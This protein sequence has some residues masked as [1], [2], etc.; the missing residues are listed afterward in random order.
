[1][2]PTNL[3]KPLKDQVV[4]TFFSSKSVKSFQKSFKQDMGYQG[5]GPAKDYW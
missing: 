4:K 1:M 2:C 3:P 5:N